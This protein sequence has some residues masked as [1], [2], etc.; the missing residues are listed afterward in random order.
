M[1]ILEDDQMKHTCQHC[2]KEQ[3]T[4]PEYGWPGDT[5]AVFS[6][7]DEK[8]SKAVYKD[9]LSRHTAIGYGSDGIMM[10]RRNKVDFEP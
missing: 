4:M 8:C 9:F 1:V 3:D 6:A 5:D 2:G 7:C 10:Y